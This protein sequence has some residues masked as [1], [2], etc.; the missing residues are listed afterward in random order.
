MSRLLVCPP[1]FFGI[2]YEINPW[3]RRSN[4]VNR[5]QAVEQ[6]HELMTVLEYKAGAAL[7]RMTP[8]SG[9]PDLVFTANAGIVCART[10]VVSHFRYAERQKEEAYFE[11]WFRLHGYRILTLEREHYFEGAGDLLEL[12][13][14]WFGGYRQRT[15]IRSFPVLSEWFHREIISLE[16]VDSRFYHLDTCFCPLTGGEVLYYPAAFDRYGQAA[17]H[18]RVPLDKRIA[19][20][21]AEALKFA[22]NAVCVGKHVVLPSGC[23]ETMKRL[24][25]CGY[26]VHPVTLDE[27]MKSGGSAKCLTLALN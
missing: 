18:D 2:E 8:V 27:F 22:C 3:M 15:D 9:L 1:D 10:A 4:T 16:L 20:P 26:D 11:D 25:S 21:E 17:I 24:E 19:V 6:W 14:S 5:D 13:G 12:A 7:E 23:P